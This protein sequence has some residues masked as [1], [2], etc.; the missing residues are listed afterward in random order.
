MIFHT[1]KYPVILQYNC[2]VTPVLKLHN[3]LKLE[4]VSKDS[5]NLS[6]ASNTNWYCSSLV[7]LKGALSSRWA[8]GTHQEQ[9]LL[10][11][12]GTI[13]R[14]GQQGAALRLTTN[15]MVG[16]VSRTCTTTQCETSMC[17]LQWMDHNGFVVGPR[18][19]PP[20]HS[21]VERIP[22]L[23]AVRL[24]VWWMC[25]RWWR[26]SVSRSHDVLFSQWWVYP[27]TQTTCQVLFFEYPIAQIHALFGHNLWSSTSLC[28]RLCSG[29]WSPLKHTPTSS[30]YGVLKLV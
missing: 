18:C 29:S 20:L 4:Y 1:V 10:P 16:M 27:I 8:I 7:R 23:I 30:E 9:V 5:R 21:Y 14:G 22:P 2:T 6:T 26:P 25:S 3:H 11:M 28:L 12:S 13:G 24:R 17:L 19:R 15:P